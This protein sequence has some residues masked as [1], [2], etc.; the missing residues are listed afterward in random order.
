MRYALLFF[1]LPLFKMSAQ[2]TYDGT[3]REELNFKT[4]KRVL[5]TTLKNIEDFEAIHAEYKL[6]LKII[7]NKKLHTTIVLGQKE[8]ILYS[9]DG[10]QFSLK[11]SV[12][13]LKLTDEVIKLIGGMYFGRAEVDKLNKKSSL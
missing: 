7:L 3:A 1:L 6:S 4:N 5:E 10:R 8:N 11:P 9:F 13:A 2:Y 12:S